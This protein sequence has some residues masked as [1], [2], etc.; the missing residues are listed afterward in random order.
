MNWT[1]LIAVA[2][3]GRQTLPARIVE[4]LTEAIRSGMVPRGE[5]LPTERALAEELG[6]ARDSVRRAYAEL[7]RLQLIRS[8]QGSGYY[9]T[10]FVD[11]STRRKDRALRAI[12]TMID[13]LD[14]LGFS[15]GEIRD[16]VQ[17]LLLDRREQAG[18][19]HLAA[20]DCNPEALS[21]YERQLLHA[22]HHTVHT[23]LLDDIQAAQDPVRLLGAYDLIIVTTNHY[24]RLMALIPELGSRLVQAVLTPTAETLRSLSKIS[25]AN[26]I[27]IACRS[28]RF[29]EIVEGHL[30][31]RSIPSDGIRYAFAPGPVELTELLGQSDVLILAAGVPM[32]G[33][34]ELMAAAARFHER[35]GR[36]IRFNY[37]IEKG[38]LLHIDERL[39]R[40]IM[41]RS[42]NTETEA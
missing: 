15:H 12:W 8:V 10:G 26:R 2:E 41:E 29:L 18:T 39:T 42:S 7:T 20:V 21:V 14:E 31:P 16:F 35:G 24:R 38:S 13:E 40:L 28:R 32:E 37:Q 27:G 25:H 36:L 11:E 4:R 33:S 34:N 17:V 1:D 9:V 3:K 30:S 19:I 5:K 6:V 22:A 23:Y